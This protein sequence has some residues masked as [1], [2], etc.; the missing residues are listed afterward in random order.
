[1]KNEKRKKKKQR[2]KRRE[3]NKMGK[4]QKKKEM[5]EDKAEVV[6]IRIIMVA[7]IIYSAITCEGLKKLHRVAK[8]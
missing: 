6:N 2:K 4:K 1:M 7:K 8:A 3:K 5:E